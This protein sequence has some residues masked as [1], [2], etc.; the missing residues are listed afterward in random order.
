MA[1]LARRVALRLSIWNIG[2]VVL[3]EN[4]VV[5]LIAVLVRAAMIGLKFVVALRRLDSVGIEE[6]SE[7]SLEVLVG[8]VGVSSKVKVKRSRCVTV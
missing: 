7:L 2:V 6:L 4:L 8:T 1:L 3:L 5:G